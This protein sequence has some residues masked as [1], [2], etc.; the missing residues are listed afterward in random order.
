M[1][2]SCCLTDGADSGLDMTLPSGEMGY[3]SDSGVRRRETPKN[4]KPSRAT[5]H[6]RAVDRMYDS[7]TEGLMRVSRPK[8]SGLT[9]LEKAKQAA[10]RQPQIDGR[11]V[12]QG[13]E[14]R[15]SLHEDDR[16]ME[17]SVYHSPP[18]ALRTGMSVSGGQTA[19][20][21]STG[22]GVTVT[23][24][25]AV[26]T[27]ET[28]PARTHQRNP[29]ASI[30]SPPASVAS[31]PAVT[32]PILPSGGR[33]LNPGHGNV[34]VGPDPPVSRMRGVSPVVEPVLRPMSAG[35]GLAAMLPVGRG[36][37]I[38]QSVTPQERKASPVKEVSPSA[39]STRP[40]VGRGAGIM[41]S[42]SPH[43]R[44]A[45][46]ARAVSPNDPSTRPS[47]GRGLMQPTTPE[48]K[49]S[50]PA[51]ESSSSPSSR[52]Q[53][54]AMIGRGQSPPQGPPSGV[55]GRS[56]PGFPPAA[57]PLSVPHASPTLADRQGSPGRGFVPHTSPTL[58]DRQ[59]SPG[60]G[61]T[62]ASRSTLSP[63]RGFITT[64]LSPTPPSLL[65]A[66][67]DTAGLL[68]RVTSS[69]LSA[70]APQGDGE[71]STQAA[72]FL[73][74][75]QT[76][77]KGPDTGQQSSLSVDVNS[78]PSGAMPELKSPPSPTR[79]GKPKQPLG[80]GPGVSPSISSGLNSGHQ[81]SG[82]VKVAND[83]VQEESCLGMMRATKAKIAANIRTETTKNV[84]ATTSKTSMQQPTMPSSAKEQPSAPTPDVSQLAIGRGR[85]FLMKDKMARILEASKARGA[86]GKPLTSSQAGEAPE[87]PK[88][89]SSTQSSAIHRSPLDDVVTKYKTAAMSPLESRNWGHSMTSP[90]GTIGRGGGLVSPQA[91]SAAPNVGRGTASVGRTAMGGP[92]TKGTIPVGRQ[93]TDSMPPDLENI[94][95]D[96]EEAL[97]QSMISVK[98]VKL[99][100][101]ATDIKDTPKTASSSLGKPGLHKVQNKSAQALSF[102]QAAPVV[103]SSGDQ[104][105][106][107]VT[108]AP[109]APAASQESQD[110]AA[111]QLQIALLKQ[112]L[113]AL[114]AREALKSSAPMT[115]NSSQPPSQPSIVQ[116]NAAVTS[117]TSTIPTKSTI[118]TNNQQSCNKNPVG[119]KSAPGV[120]AV[121]QVSHSEP[122]DDDIPFN[123]IS[124]KSIR[125][126]V[127]PKKPVTE[128]QDKDLP[129]D[130]I[131]VRCIKPKASSSSKHASS[132]TIKEPTAIAP[133]NVSQLIPSMAAAPGSS[134]DILMSTQL[135]PSLPTSAC[136]TGDLPEAA[137]EASLPPASS[138]GAAAETLDMPALEEM[139]AVAAS[140]M[141]PLQEPVGASEMPA[142]EEPDVASE[143]PPL[144]ELDAACE[145]P[146][147]E[148]P[149]VASEMPPLEE[150][151]VDEGSG[152]A[153]SGA[154][155]C[156]LTPG[157]DV[158]NVTDLQHD[159]YDLTTANVSSSFCPSVDMATVTSLQPSAIDV[160]SPASSLRMSSGSPSIDTGPTKS[161]EAKSRVTF[162]DVDEYLGPET[163]TPS[164]TRKAILKK[165]ASSSGSDA[166][167][168][169]SYEL[170]RWVSARKT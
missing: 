102:S 68:G 73:R 169:N 13:T 33:G 79:V 39:S 101:Q 115:S 80:S 66:A 85:A 91:T 17:S 165:T 11:L 49:R 121:K 62:M 20:V 98:N 112:Q 140:E 69:H 87:T 75:A 9:L 149:D 32:S 145:M 128:P 65:P 16:S 146:P 74:F 125:P 30:T 45:S 50:S 7:D 127:I 168:Y 64:S 77:Q 167:R 113:Q 119:H 51:K 170:Y 95:S 37:G 137:G 107:P 46:P 133:R 109:S 129:T 162:S 148:E 126:K 161:R 31:Q 117:T 135:D 104:G 10:G 142:L 21:L 123:F 3:A 105:F 58:A 122:S 159:H 94:D 34:T 40:S 60:R 88:N 12:S 54:P 52:P 8:S 29:E 76:L 138:R 164:P 28:S 15:Q 67:G 71:H 53:L 155:I 47:V 143:M 93:V 1:F 42:A 124:V 136:S 156:S 24:Q 4:V 6:R 2:A 150:P 44:R 147:L 96:E 36:A 144:E 134:E 160:V 57:S 59:V 120:T 103:K 14:P 166:E 108:S 25:C 19:G 110:T 114:S 100:K 26:R 118:P 86:P 38:M 130:F 157:A 70:V 151:D 116:S 81:G 132:G 152:V 43:E 23:D 22:R 55:S 78:H 72:A 84:S 90:P 35:R 41:Q 131:S 158:S 83:I 141:D 92:A 154:S 82:H 63:G 48:G 27:S 5:H 163:K 99:G 61:F 106:V 111:L 56:L 139:D 89:I 153:D 18:E 97:L